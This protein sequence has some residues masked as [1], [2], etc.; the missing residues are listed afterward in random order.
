MGYLEVRGTKIEIEPCETVKIYLEDCEDLTI[1][2]RADVR[3]KEHPSLADLHIA[4]NVKIEGPTQVRD[5]TCDVATITGNVLGD[6]KTRMINCENIHG[7]VEG[8]SVWATTI[9][10]NVDSECVVV[11]RAEGK[12][13]ALSCA[14][15]S[16]DATPAE[17]FE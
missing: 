3:K 11:H 6:V 12:V 17:D 10:G 1:W 5:L 14:T 9:K 16:F 13:E 2:V 8:E 4:G 15:G 7:N